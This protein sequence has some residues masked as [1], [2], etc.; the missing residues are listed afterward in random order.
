MCVVMP[1]FLALVDDAMRSHWQVLCSKC[2]AVNDLESLLVAFVSS[3][4][5]QQEERS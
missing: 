5:E 1:F 4:R 2:A 3:E